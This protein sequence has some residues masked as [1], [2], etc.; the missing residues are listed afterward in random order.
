MTFEMKGVGPAIACRLAATR[1]VLADPGKRR[2]LQRVSL[3]VP[4]D[5]VV[6]ALKG[7]DRD[8][9]AGAAAAEDTHDVPWLRRV[10]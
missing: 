5:D 7:D 8:T 3:N 6:Y 1:L 9:T 10:L 4:R 2:G